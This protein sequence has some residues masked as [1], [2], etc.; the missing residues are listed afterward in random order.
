MDGLSGAASVLAVF[1]LALSSTQVIY[2]T[3]SGIK[4]APTTI[5]HMISSLQDLSNLLEQ[6]KGCTEQFHLAADLGGLVGKCA[7]DLKEFEEKLA[8]LNTPADNKAVR[9]WK[10]IKVTLRERDLVKVSGL[11]QQHVAALSLQM[12]IIEGYAVFDTMD[13]TLIP[14]S[15]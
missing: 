4:N 9:L 14:C 8:K 5:Q 11:I 1:S 3:V 10:S 13:F 7:A 6:L 12:Q 15:V 2:N